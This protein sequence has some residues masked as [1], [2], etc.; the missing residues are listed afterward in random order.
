MLTILLVVACTG[1][2]REDRS[3]EPTDSGPVEPPSSGIPLVSFAGAPPSNVLVVSLDT[4]RRDWVGRYGPHADTPFLD[5]LLAAGV[6]LD[7]HRSCSDWTAPSMA[8]VVTGLFPPT[9][10]FWPTPDPI[11]GIVDMPAGVQTLAKL[12]GD[13]GRASRLVSANPTFG[14]QVDGLVAGF[15]DV[16][17]IAWKAAGAVNTVGLLKLDE[18]L[19]AGGPWM[20]H[21]HFLDPHVSYCPP[22]EYIPPPETLPA[23]EWD[24]CGQLPN[25]IEEWPSQTEEWRAAMQAHVDAYYGA[26]LRYLDDS[27]ELLWGELAARGAL[28]DTF[29]MLVSDHGEQFF[30]HGG[31]GHAYELY[32]EENLAIA[33]FLAPGLAPVAWTGPTTHADLFATLADVYDLAPE[34]PTDGIVVG[35]ADPERIRLA[36]QVRPQVSPL[37]GEVWTPLRV[38]AVGSTHVLHADWSETFELYDLVTDPG[39]TTDL[40]STTPLAPGP[41]ADVLLPFLA[42]VKTKWS[43]LGDETPPQE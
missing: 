15:D 4:L 28:D 9:H 2:S 16:T 31:H 21:L 14:Y 41:L 30:D 38:A 35:L 37:E 34:V 36:M 6:T 42:D 33:A 18:M 5:S 7:N 11:D 13:Q 43:L 19:A 17:T 12:L 23:F 27:L 39:E 10:D 1:E 8:C 40:Y 26:E 32:G 22:E 20:L 25:A 29:V 3:S 24:M